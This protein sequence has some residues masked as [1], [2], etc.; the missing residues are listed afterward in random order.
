[1]RPSGR[2]SSSS[3]QFPGDDEGHLKREGARTERLFQGKLAP[4]CE[5]PFV[6]FEVSF[7]F[8]SKRTGVPS[9]TDET[10][11]RQLPESKDSFKFRYPNAGEVP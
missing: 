3:F 10:P 9:G 11:R 8:Q 5:F 7:L 2:L 1:M 4:V 6:C